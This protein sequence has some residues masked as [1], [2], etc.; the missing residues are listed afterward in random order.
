MKERK[1]DI[2]KLI[3]DN[4]YNNTPLH[5][6]E[7]ITYVAIIDKNIDAKDLLVTVM[8]NKGEDM[9]LNHIIN[10]GITAKHK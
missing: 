10:G 4:V 3:H 6:M 1:T 2:K 5:F 8:K 7:H 9:L